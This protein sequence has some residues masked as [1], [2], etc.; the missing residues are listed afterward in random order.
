MPFNKQMANQIVRSHDQRY[1]FNTTQQP[2]N[3]KQ[4]NTLYSS[5]CFGRGYYTYLTANTSSID[6]ERFDRQMSGIHYLNTHLCAFHDEIPGDL[7]FAGYLLQPGRGNPGRRVMGVGLSHGFQEQAS[8]LD[9]TGCAK[10]RREKT[11]SNRNLLSWIRRRHCNSTWC[12]PHVWGSWS[13]DLWGNPS[14]LPPSVRSQSPTPEERREV[15]KTI[16]DPMNP[17]YWD[18]MWQTIDEWQNRVKDD[19]YLPG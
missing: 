17:A 12:L 15:D 1:R 6:I 16:N 3:D 10:P 19:Q 13:W 18:N 8:L 11:N 4:I 9:V 7:H 2:A 5:L 14:D